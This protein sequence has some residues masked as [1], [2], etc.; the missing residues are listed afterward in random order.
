MRVPTI[1]SA[2]VLVA[3]LMAQAVLRCEEPKDV[4]YT[5]FARVSLMAVPGK[6]MDKDVI[7]IL[8]YR[9]FNVCDGYE[10]RSQCVEI[11]RG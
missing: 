4:F 6:I 11:F 2:A 10:I 8:R 9:F 1:K 7:C 5:S 3:L